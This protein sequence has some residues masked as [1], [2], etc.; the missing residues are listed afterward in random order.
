MSDLVFNLRI[1][2]YHF[3]IG[4]NKPYFR[5]VKNGMHKK[6]KLVALYQVGNW[7]NN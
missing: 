4:R 3:Q 2:I 6:S 5:V 1:W 7:H